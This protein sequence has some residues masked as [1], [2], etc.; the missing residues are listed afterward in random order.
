[1]REIKFRAWDNVDYMSKPFTLEDVRNRN[2]E[3]TDDVIIMQYTGLQ[4]KN[5]KEIYDGDVVRS[6]R[7]RTVCKIVFQYGAFRFDLG[8]KK[9]AVEIE[10]EVIGNIYENPELLT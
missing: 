2:V 7:H 4:D 5:G 9:Y 6:D 1:M 3:F 10:C 8:T